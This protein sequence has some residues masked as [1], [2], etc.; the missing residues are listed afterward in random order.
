M[1]IIIAVLNSFAHV[2]ICET[3]YESMSAGCLLILIQ[4]IISQLPPSKCTVDD[5]L[6]AVYCSHVHQYLIDF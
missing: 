2:L 4:M 6:K 1:S 3:K 5:S